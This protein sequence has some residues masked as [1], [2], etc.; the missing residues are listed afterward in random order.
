[1]WAAVFAEH[2]SLQNMDD[3]ARDE[4]TDE[5]ELISDGESLLVVG[6]GRSVERFLRSKG[7]LE[8]AQALGSAQLAGAVRSSAA[9]VETLSRAASESALWL[10]ITPESADAIAEFGLT[11][12]TVPGVSYAMAGQRGDIKS[13]L[14]VDSTAKAQLQNPALLS[15]LAGAMSQLAREQEAAQLRA[16]L[17]TIDHKLDQVLRG[18][19][20]EIIGD[21]SGIERELRA[22]SRTLELEGAI[23]QTTWS[24]NDSASR[25]LRQVQAKAVLKLIGIAEDLE[26]LKRVGELRARLISAR[27]EVR[28]WLTVISRCTTA[29]DE[30]AILELNYTAANNPDQLDALDARRV[31]LDTLRAEDRAEVHAALST[32]VTRLTDAAER[33]NGHKVLHFRAVPEVFKQVI[34]ARDAARRTGEAL[35]IDVDWAE[36]GAIRWRDAALQ[37]SQ[38]RNGVTDGAT[39]AWEKSKP[40][41]VP[42]AISAVGTVVLAAFKGSTDSSA[43]TDT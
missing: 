40:I 7:L 29:L 19:R 5:V 42:L 33:A 35:G 28:L 10:K 1:M 14:K 21:L 43:S 4:A 34:D 6:E 18:Q 3:D 17:E 26:A 11:D 31:T 39:I 12:T 24:K 15:G 20:D 36:V 25:E 13:W 37:P 9:F 22:A 27:E 23:D 2:R 41:V 38:W 32:L 16:L 30:H 8:R